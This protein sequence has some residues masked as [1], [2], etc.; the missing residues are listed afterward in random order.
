MLACMF[1]I[2][3]LGFRAC[4]RKSSKLCQWHICALTCTC[5]SNA[6]ALLALLVPTH[7]HHLLICPSGLQVLHLPCFCLFCRLLSSKSSCCS[8]LSL[9]RRAK[10]MPCFIFALH[11]RS[12]SLH[13][14][15]SATQRWQP[16]Q[17]QSLL[18]CKPRPK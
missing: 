14:I 1:L 11:S 7:F 10:S 18:L 3:F 17:E 12:L 13:L 8:M 4:I 6:S 16:W 2:W 15:G 9:F 5:L